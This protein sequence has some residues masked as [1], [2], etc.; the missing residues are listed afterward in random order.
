MDT[1]F[2][3]NNVKNITQILV[4]FY[5][6]VVYGVLGL[7][8]LGLAVG[9][10]PGLRMNRPTIAFVGSSFLISLGAINLDEAWQAI[11]VKTIIFL[12]SMMVVNA[13]LTYGGFFAR[14]L[15]LLLRLTR[16]PLGLLIAL[17]V[18]TGVLSAFFLNDTLAL[19]FTPF[20][21]TLTTALKLNPIP[22]LLAL[23][24]ATNIGSVATLSGNPQNI[25][26]GSFSGIAYLDFLANGLPIAVAGMA[27]QIILLY[28]FYP[29]VR[30]TVPCENFSLDNQRI[31]KPLF[32][33]TLFIVA[34]LLI[35]FAIGL[36]LAQTA[37]IA[38]SLLL[39]TRRLKPERIL[40]K[41][42][43]NLI[44]MFSGLFILSKVTQKLN[45][46]Q[47]FTGIINTSI[48]LISVTSVLSNLISNV[49][50]VLLLE[51]LIPSYDTQS[52]L[53][54]AFSSTLAGNLTLFGAVANLITVEAAASLG[55]RLTF[56][57]HL[58]FGAPLT[59]LTLGFVYWW[60][61]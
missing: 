47:P 34:G 28:V 52:W 49:P 15:Y 51:P 61:R 59:V 30:S 42:D 7:T 39:I 57:E 29:E 35:G 40:T 13:N 58:R 21:L 12:L 20:T 37:L 11:D 16:S 4:S 5:Q 44:L 6:I 19:I 27:I 50:A 33:K 2:R 10:V 53:L 45:L 25:L 14:A 54:L 22:Y 24:A 46:I 41:L 3:V 26:I 38:A 36:P 17:T 60:V 31:Y 43:W 48:G 8:Y 23:A 18:G 56:W 9:Y 1:S 32:N 55:Y